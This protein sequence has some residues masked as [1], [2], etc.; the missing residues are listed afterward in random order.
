M[1]AYAEVKNQFRKAY[2][3]DSVTYE[4]LVDRAD[5]AWRALIS[6]FLL[7]SAAGS[8]RIRSSRA[9]RRSRKQV[10]QVTGQFGSRRPAQVL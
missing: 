8:R 5:Q 2:V 9:R 4:G 10:L 7:G 3:E 6:I 1:E